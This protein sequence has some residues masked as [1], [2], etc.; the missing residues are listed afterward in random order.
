[1]PLTAKVG[2]SLSRPGNIQLGKG[3]LRRTVRAAVSGTTP[4]YRVQVFSF[5]ATF[6]IGSLLVEFENV[7]NIGWAIYLNDVPEAYFTINQDDPKIAR[8]VG[9]VG[10]CHLR[11]YRGDDLVWTGLLMDADESSRDVVFY[12]YGYVAA[13]YWLVSD[14]NQV[15]TN[16]TVGSIASTLWTRAKS[17]ITYSNLAFVAT[18]TIQNPATTSGGTTD[19]V[20]PNYQLYRKRILF[21]LQELAAL[22][23]SDT[24][25]SVVFEI[26]HSLTP[27]FNLWK[28]RGVVAPVRWQ[29]GGVIAD[30]HHPVSQ[31]W[32]RNDVYI[33]GADPHVT[34]L[35]LEVE[36]VPDEQAWGRR[37]EPIFLTWVRDQTEMT[38]TG[39]LR[40]KQAL[41]PDVQLS[42]DLVPNGVIPPGATG[43]LFKLSDS[44]PIYINRGLTQVNANYR[45]VGVRVS[46]ADGPEQMT[47][48]LQVAP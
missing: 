9:L 3:S 19:I 16:Q 34:L 48:M 44:I 11:I 22:S 38:R 45:V 21:A 41:R 32:R 29:Y 10:K 18:G 26:T 8:L 42:V 46:R 36:S 39:N 33:L 6:G 27:T 14:W 1:M 43:A 4:Q 25:N 30:Y 12:A 23:I 2:T 31:V 28:N 35:R 13:L 5:D 7:K 17:V 37:Q 24:S 20:L 47:A 15:F 40:L